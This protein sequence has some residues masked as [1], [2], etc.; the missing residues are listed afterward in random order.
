MG[1]DA[2]VI[3]LNTVFNREGVLPPRE[4]IQGILVT[5]IPWCGSSRYPLAPSVI[6]HIGGADLIHVHAIDFFACN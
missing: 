2:Q 1:I 6:A 3:T 4:S 5:R